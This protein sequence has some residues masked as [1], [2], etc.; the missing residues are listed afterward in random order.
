MMYSNAPM[1]GGPT[2][3]TNR[4]PMDRAQGGMR[5]GVAAIMAAMR[6]QKPG[7]SGM[8]QQVAPMSV[9][10]GV[11]PGGQMAEPMA[12]PMGVDPN[13]RMDPNARQIPLYRQ[14]PVSSTEE[15]GRMANSARFQSLPP[16]I[17]ARLKPFFNGY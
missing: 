17:Q 3:D 1:T 15:A 9:G 13:A 7:M 10:S 16:E 2:L 6:G 14:R 11:V 5:P 8:P 12:K 4:Q